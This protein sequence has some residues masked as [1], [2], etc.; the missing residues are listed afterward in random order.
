MWHGLV[1]G[2][3][4]FDALVRYDE[5]ITQRVAA[6]G[7]PRCG[8]R[9]HR[10]DYERKPRG[11]TI[12]A[13]GEAFGRRFS[14]CCSREGCRKRVTPPSLRFLGRRVYL[15]AA[16]LVACAVAFTLGFTA[17]LRAA[18]GIPAQ[19][20][21]R[22]DGWWRT[23][24][25]TST[26]FVALRGQLMP[27]L[28]TDELPRSLLERLGGSASERVERALRLVA[29]LS[30]RSLADGARFLR[31]GVAPAEDDI[32]PPNPRSVGSNAH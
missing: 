29:P 10:S 8:G 23:I 5:Q 22:W 1:L 27:P 11:G 4:F 21:R 28:D 30:T 16:M 2:R 24:F 18:L 32:S 15:G 9:L 25:V 19:T 20:V 17:A 31:E 26:V 13:A 12:A 7:C 14:L 3:E 6:A